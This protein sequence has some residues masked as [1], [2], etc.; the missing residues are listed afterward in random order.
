MFLPPAVHA[1]VGHASTLPVGVRRG[2]ASEAHAEG[3]AAATSSRFVT[4]LMLPC[5]ALE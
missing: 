2:L 5:V 4:T 3:V 1:A